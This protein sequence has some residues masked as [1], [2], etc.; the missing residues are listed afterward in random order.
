MAQ[1]T[2]SL[3]KHP[4]LIVDDHPIVRRGL[5]DVINETI[6]L[7]ICGEA[8]DVPEAI[9]QIEAT[10]PHAVIVDITLG[11]EDG[12]ELIDCIKW[13]W[14]SIKILVSSAR[15]EKT[16]AGRVLR[17]GALGFISKREP[18]PQVVNALRQVLRGEVYLSPHMTTC[19]LQRA[20]GRQSL[21]PDP[22]QSLSNRELQVF[23]LIG[24][25]LNTREIAQRL[26]IS[27]K[28]VES[29]RKVL[30]EKLNAPTSSHLS[31]QAFQWVQE[32]R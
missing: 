31:R 17:A 10:Q 20:A 29:H 11:D 27:P 14:P 21:E 5:M 19:L 1:P 32:N 25:G 9:R 12:I 22:V 30:K 6:D 4:V 28:T 2:R 24:E 15:D 18:L 7:E 16:F 23:Q 13:R 8:A 26:G 3:M